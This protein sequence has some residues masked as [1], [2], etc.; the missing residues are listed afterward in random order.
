MADRHM[1][2]SEYLK[3]QARYDKAVTDFVG[4]FKSSLK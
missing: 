1:F 4:Y 2:E 3:K